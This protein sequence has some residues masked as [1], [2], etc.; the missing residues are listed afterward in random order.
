MLRK[1]QQNQQKKSNEDK[2]FTCKLQSTELPAGGFNNL[3]APWGYIRTTD[4]VHQNKSNVK[5]VANFSRDERHLVYC[6]N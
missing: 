5:F 3:D 1:R 6:D 4:A 2:L